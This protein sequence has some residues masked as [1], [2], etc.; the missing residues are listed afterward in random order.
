[1]SV[2]VIKAGLKDAWAHSYK[3]GAAVSAD[4]LQ[5]LTLASI[6]K[7]HFSSITAESAMKMDFIQP[8]EGLWDTR[9]ADS[10]ADFARRHGIQMRGHVLLS[11]AHTP[12]WVFMKGSDKASAKEVTERLEAHIW[13]LASRYGDAAYAWDVVDEVI[14]RTG[15]GLAA[16][17]WTKTCG[18]DIYERA[19]RTAHE[20]MPKARLFYND[21]NIES[22]PKMEEAI[23]FLSHLL[24]KGVPLHGIG[25]QGHWN[26]DYPDEDMLRE[27][28]R[29]YSDLG[30]D[31]EITELDISAYPRE[32]T[33]I[34]LD[35]IPE[36]R[37]RQQAHRFRSIFRIASDYPAVKSITTWGIADDHTWLENHPIR[38]RKNWPLLFDANL[39]EKSTVPVLIATGFSLGN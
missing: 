34:R 9:D 12:P 5:N 24:E 23:G 6:V 28:F 29:R 1:M 18:A 10:I 13:F 31:I 11:P 19:F 17:E 15:R 35:S 30:L 14:E 21:F 32:D 25:I 3:I 20:A 16:N 7:E 2:K 27:A 36:E 33:G 4:R 22:G 39:A 38:N 26:Y 8:E 37:S